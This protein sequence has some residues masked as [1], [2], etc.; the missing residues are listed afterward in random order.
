MV[1][2][3]VVLK[4][5]V[6]WAFHIGSYRHVL[7]HVRSSSCDSEGHNGRSERHFSWLLIFLHNCIQRFVDLVLLGHAVFRFVTFRL[8]SL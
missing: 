4:T 5:D 7:H 6:E 8:E 1:S 2:L 3:P